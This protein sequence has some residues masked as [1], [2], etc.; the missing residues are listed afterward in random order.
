MGGRI[1]L[2]PKER[3]E[4]TAKGGHSLSEIGWHLS[5]KLSAGF[6]RT[7]LMDWLYW[8]GKRT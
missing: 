8:K 3:N 2:I 4:K 5:I 7:G 6:S 1:G